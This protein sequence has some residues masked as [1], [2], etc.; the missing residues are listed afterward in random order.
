MNL[1][2]TVAVQPDRGV[3]VVSHDSRVYDLGDRIVHLSDGRV[4]RVETPRGP[5]GGGPDR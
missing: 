5:G 2:R 4:D 3:I 1:I